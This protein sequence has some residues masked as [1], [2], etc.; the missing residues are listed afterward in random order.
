MPSAFTEFART[1]VSSVWASNWA[2]FGAV[3]G[4]ATGKLATIR[5]ICWLS[6]T[7]S[8]RSSGS[9]GA[10]PSGLVSEYCNRIRPLT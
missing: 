10:V 9:G 5:S 7:M 2:A 6:F 1:Q 8:A 4:A 3:H